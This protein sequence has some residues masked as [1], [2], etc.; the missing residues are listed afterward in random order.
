MM[1]LL[2]AWLAS[3]TVAQAGPAPLSTLVE[4]S[5]AQADDRPLYQRAPLALAIDVR[6]RT[7][8][9]LSVALVLTPGQ[10]KYVSVLYRKLPDPFRELTYTQEWEQTDP[11]EPGFEV[12]ALDGHATGRV[13]MTLAADPGRSAF[14]F[15]E[16]G[17]YEVQLVSRAPWLGSEDVMTTPS[18]RI[19][20]EPAPPSESAALA[21]WDVDLAVFAQNDAGGATSSAPRFRRDVTRAL[22]FMDKHAGSLYA[23][24]LRQR[25]FD[26]LHLLRRLGRPLTGYES[27]AFE[28]LKLVMREETQHEAQQR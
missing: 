7:D 13:G 23:R 15:G 9:K 1:A 3:P 17:D 22:K 4:I 6:N 5:L 2:V 19:H 14:L 24:A 21:D 10:Y 11:V 16:P 28:R 26:T 25:T 8:R 12:F 27:D 20:V 18:L